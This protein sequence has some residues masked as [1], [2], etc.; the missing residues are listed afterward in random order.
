[1]APVAARL[2]ACLV[3]LCIALPAAALER[4]IA[5]APVPDWALDRDLPRA[6]AAGEAFVRQGVEVL[7]RDVQMRLE[8]L[9]HVRLHREVRAVTD[10]IGLEPAG[11]MEIEYDPETE[12]LTLH[13][14]EVRRGSAR[15]DRIGLETAAL[16]READLDR[17][18]LDGRLTLHGSVPG[19][20]VGDVVDLIWSVRVRPTIF[21]DRFH[22]RFAD[23][24]FDPVRADHRRIL[25]PPGRALSSRSR[26]GRLPETTLTDGWTDYA[27][28]REN[29][30]PDWP[31]RS[32]PYWTAFWGLTET[33]EFGG[34]DEIAS[35]LLPYY[36]ADDPLPPE[37]QLFVAST[38]ASGATEDARVTAA[39]RLVQDRIRYVGI[40]IGAGG[41][42][43]RPPGKVWDRG[44]GDCKD[45]ALLLVALLDAMGI[46]SD[47][48]LVHSE[49]GA[50]LPQTLASPYAFDHAI[51]RVR[52]GDGDYFLDPTQVLQGGVARDIA[53]GAFHWG[54]PL[55]AGADALV[56]IARPALDEPLE[57]VEDR[58]DFAAV[59]PEGEEAARFTV[60]TRFRGTEA[61]RMRVALR[62]TPLSEWI[63]D[64]IDYYDTRFPGIRATHDLA[65][66]DDF[67]ANLITI[68]ERYAIP[69]AAMAEEGLW[70]AFK[71]S[72]ETV[73]G[74]VWTGPEGSAATHPVA[75]ER[76]AVR[77]A[78]TLVGL[79]NPLN[80]PPEI[81]IAEGPVRFVRTGTRDETGTELTVDWRL[82][83]DADHLLPRDEPLW[84]G[85][86]EKVEA[87][88]D[89]QYDL[90]WR[91]PGAAAADTPV[92]AGIGARTLWGWGVGLLLCLVGAF[93]V[94]RGWRDP[95]G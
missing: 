81:D 60:T 47:V 73:K 44:Y 35:G 61:D 25:V 54:L 63:A 77:H 91:G 50:G 55:A 66:D 38:L 28:S 76:L 52:G 89:W 26:G 74:K 53:V 2:I 62:T 27:W 18:I 95:L 22:D 10:R 57:D 45:K 12:D 33:G 68:T 9:G 41:Y 70:T 90:H 78:V 24:V 67:D 58:F 59:D 32:Y 30:L 16:R 94:R 56:P 64:Y 3:A 79:P 37:L 92:V 36:V 8:P 46:R 15:I 49:L 17:G 42:I 21:A 72:P 85:T 19:L 14:V 11:R 69:R 65:V 71:L 51:V 82:T 7:M 87:E 75:V 43:P 40:E 84:R 93:G 48:T 29:A 23:R 5:R 34:W 80:P 31:D 86:V 1:M 6:G 4:E 83:V 88:D 39:F 20:R 13:R